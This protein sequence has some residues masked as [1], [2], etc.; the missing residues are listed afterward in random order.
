VS[1]TDDRVGRSGWDDDPTGPIDLGKDQRPSAPAPRVPAGWS[2]TAANRSPAPPLP[3]YQTR[4]DWMPL[5]RPTNTMA[6][7]SLVL[8]VCSFFICPLLG[9][10]AVIVGNRARREI[11][12]TGEQGDGL[13]SAG[14]A[15]GYV[16]LG[17]SVFGMAI[18]VVLALFLA[19]AATA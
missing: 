2:A 5:S 9:I 18:Y 17:L 14:I 1:E 15:M 16:V 3:G 6:T 11:R 7:T 8:G 10:A 4:I 13:A 19:A 12:Q